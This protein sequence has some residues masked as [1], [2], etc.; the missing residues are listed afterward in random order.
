MKVQE[1]MT[2]EVK[3]CGRDSN[4]A[5]VAK[6][7]WDGDCG[8]LPVV[9]DEGNVTGIISDRDIC[10][11]VATKGRLAAEILAS[12]VASGKPLHTCAPDDDI[13]H[14]LSAMQ[15]HQVRRIPVINSDGRIA[16]ILSISDVINATNLETRGVKQGVSTNEAISTLKGICEPRHAAQNA[17]AAASG[18][19]AQ[20]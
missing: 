16:G 19:A 7:L 9:D 4:L 20:A 8:A 1:L 2:K 15:Q 6:L 14:A 3:T 11:A 17:A 13:Q 18:S 12:E 10:F 5:E